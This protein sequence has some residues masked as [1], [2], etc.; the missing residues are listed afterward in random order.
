MLQASTGSAAIAKALVDA[1]A[2]VNVRDRWGGTPLRDAV[3]QGHAEVSEMLRQA[4][5]ELGY[6]ETEASG[7]LCELAKEGALEKLKIL[8][9]CGVTVNAADYDKR[10]ALH[11]A[12]RV[13]RPHHPQ[14]ER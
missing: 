2:N 9:H 3:R 12:V 10:T 8:L 1:G 11:L 5:G 14:N 7:E 4:E 13:N 6:N